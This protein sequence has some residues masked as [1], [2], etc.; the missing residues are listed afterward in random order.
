[1]AIRFL[2]SVRLRPQ[3][4]DFAK[5]AVESICIKGDVRLSTAAEILSLCRGITNLALW[6]APSDLDFHGGQNPLSR[7]LEALPLLSLSLSISLVFCHSS[8]PS[9]S[10]LKVFATLTHLEILNCWVLWGSTVGLECL[11]GLTHL[12]LHVHTRRTKPAL[13]MP[14][15]SHLHLQVLVFRVSES[16]SL[17]QRFLEDAHLSDTRIVLKTQ[18]LTAWGDL[19]SKD[20][21]LWKDAEQIVKWRYANQGTSFCPAA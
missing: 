8:Y 3:H 13:V 5:G 15:L 12:C 4:H 1:M 2:S 18:A 20:M 10:A 21:S 19:G 14:L 17:V 6:V 7:P 9:L 16:F 11:H